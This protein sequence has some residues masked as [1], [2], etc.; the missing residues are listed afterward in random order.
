MPVLTR[1][2]SDNP[3]QETWQVF[4]E[5]V[6]VGTIGERAGVPVGVDRWHW[7]CGFYPG[8]EPGQHRQGIAPTF[9]QARAGF[10]ADWAIL[11]PEIPATAFDEKRYWTAFHRWKY[12]MWDCG[13]QMPTQNTSGRSTCF[14]GAEIGV[15]CEAHIRENH[16]E[17]A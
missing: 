9:D 5:G 12:Q 3:H 4:C 6:C 8:L 15:D 14:C 11:Q 10:S 2:R 1:R 13:C 7:S 16:M 17:D